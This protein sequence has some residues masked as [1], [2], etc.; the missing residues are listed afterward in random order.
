MNG[1][2]VSAN[3]YG[4]PIGYGGGLPPLS[5]TTTETLLP[6]YGSDSV[7]ADKTHPAM[8]ADSGLTYNLPVSR[9]RTRDSVNPLIV[10]PNNQNLNHLNRRSGGSFTFLGEDISLQ[11]QHQQLEIDHFIAQHVRINLY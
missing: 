8:K 1:I 11:I 6:V 10:F 7:Q 3:M 5:G 4:A 2:D 9:K